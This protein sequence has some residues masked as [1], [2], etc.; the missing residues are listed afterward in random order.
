[1]RPFM[2]ALNK[3]FLEFT[4]ID[5]AHSVDESMI[6]YYGRHG[7]K[8]FIRGKP[9]RWRYKFWIG[10][11]RLGYI[12]WF[13][14]YQEFTSTIPNKYKNVELDSGVVL[15]FA[16]ELQKNFPNLPFHL[17]FDNFFTSLSLLH[18]LKNRGLKGTGTIKANRITDIALSHPNE[19]KKQNRDSYEYML[20]AGKKIVTCRWN[21]NNLATL[22]SNNASV[23][24]LSQV[25]RFSQREKKYIMVEQSRIIKKIQ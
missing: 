24:P 5:E 22:A 3:S 4:T 13:E 9:I 20:D 16:D 8:Q 7:T 11:T 25:K 2:N 17:Y 10:T 23:K 21:D 19:H 14:P 15:T 18:H 1:M 12:E 6:P